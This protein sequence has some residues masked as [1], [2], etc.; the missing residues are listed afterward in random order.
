MSTLS[1]RGHVTFNKQ[2]TFNGSLGAL[3]MTP[4]WTNYFSMD[5]LKAFQ[6]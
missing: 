5:F 3:F 6:V 2:I 4:K 1:T